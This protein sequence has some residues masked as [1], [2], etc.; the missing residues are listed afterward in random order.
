MPP[1]SSLFPQASDSL[2][3]HLQSVVPT[4][5]V[6]PPPLSFHHLCP[7]LQV[8]VLGPLSTPSSLAN[9]FLH[10][11]WLKIPTLDLPTW[12]PPA[13]SLF[14]V[15]PESLK[16]DWREKA[17]TVNLRCHL[18]FVAVSLQQVLRLPTNPISFPSS[19]IIPFSEATISLFIFNLSFF[20]SH[21]TSNPI[22]SVLKMYSTNDH[23]S[24]SP[25]LLSQPKMP[26]SLV[27]TIKS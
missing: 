10:R 2:H 25:L 11:A 23:V 17:N 3:P 5:S 27:S 18:K 20:P 24:S 1:L 21:L 9:L 12:S 16:F 19:F 13:H 15:T 7:G 8:S 14:Q 22:S 6:L 4:I 26:E